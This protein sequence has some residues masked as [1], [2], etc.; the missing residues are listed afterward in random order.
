MSQLAVREGAFGL[1]PLMPDPPPGGRVLE[2]TS[3]H[4]GLRGCIRL[5][6]VNNQRLELSSWQEAVTQSSGVGECGDHPC[7]PNPCLGGAPCQALEAG[8]FHCQCPSGRFGEDGA[9]SGLWGRGHARASVGVGPHRVSF[10]VQPVVMTRTP[11]SRTPAMGQPP[12]ACCLTGRPS[13]NAPRDEG[14]PSARQ[15]GALG[16]QRKEEG[17]MRRLGLSMRVWVLVGVR[18]GVQA[19]VR[20]CVR[21]GAR[22]SVELQGAP[23]V[24]LAP[25][26]TAVLSSTVSERDYS[27]P[28]LAD[29][30]GF[31]YLELK[32]LHT[33]ERD[34][35]SVGQKAR[36]REASPQPLS[37]LQGKG[38]L[39]CPHL[40]PPDPR[41][42]MALEVVFLARGPSGLLFYDGQKTDGKG[43]FVSLAL[44]DRF[45]E[46][47]YDLG[48]GAAVIRC[49]L[50]YGRGGEAGDTWRCHL[51]SW[52]GRL[53]GPRACSRYPSYQ[54]QGACGPG[55]LDQGLT[56]AQW[57][58]GRHACQ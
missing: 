17:G 18:I 40:T 12:A 54:E 8:M 55:H 26:V 43:D 47:R 14:A 30:N 53:A 31:S 49:A 46:F 24:G 28:F 39:R 25:R 37:R 9:W 33:F 5:L 16:C 51:G 36:M 44:H 48:K 4:V 7:L 34:L 2:R 29:F 35:G 56:G 52:V 32:G 42:K 6:D 19:S 20:A 45:L 27:R 3:I 1:W 23:G 22:R 57:P 38:P 15:V 58:Q 11:V 13:V 10:Q 41:E 21:P 50:A